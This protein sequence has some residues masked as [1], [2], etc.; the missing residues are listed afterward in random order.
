MRSAFVRELTSVA[1]ADPRV[2][3]LSGDL[4]YGAFEAYRTEHP[5]RFVNAGISEQNMVSVAAGLALGGMRPVVYSIAPFLVLRAA[6]QIRN[7]VCF[8]GLPVVFV[9]AGGG[10]AYGSQGITHHAVDDLAVMRLMPGMAVFAPADPVEAAA[11]VR[12]A[13]ETLHTP[14]YIRLARNGE[15]VIRSAPVD[16]RAPAL[17]TK[18]RDVAVV[19]YGPILSEIR[20]VADYLAD[21][22]VS[23]RVIGLP[24]LQPFPCELFLSLVPDGMPVVSVEEHR[25]EGGIGTI[26]GE[27]LLA[28]GRTNRL[29]SL[30]VRSQYP[31]VAGSQSFLLKHEGLD[32]LTVS[33]RIQHWLSSL[34][35]AGGEV[36]E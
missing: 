25:V 12:Y 6:E 31:T 21:A 26:V 17:Y 1:A 36:G 3:L 35:R 8:H 29:L 19:S 20:A 24:M 9:G 11:V 10:F 13:L 16:V 34:S 23:A 27:V 7:D 14:A 4:G 2:L 28:T 30:G 5:S 18:G 32:R 22:G 33:A 15:P